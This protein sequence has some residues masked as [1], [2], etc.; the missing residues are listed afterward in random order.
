MSFLGKSFLATD[1]LSP[2]Q[3]LF[4]FEKARK[5]RDRKPYPAQNKTV[6]LMFFEPSTRTRASFEMAA[7]RLGLHV[8]TLDPS[9]SSVVKGETIEDTAANIEA[10]GPDCI[11]VRHSGAG[12]PQQLSRKVKIPV[13]NAG[14]GMRG[15]PTQALLDAFTILEERGQI[16]GEKVL[17]VGD[18]MHS[19]VARSNFE[20]LTKLGASIGV[21]GPATLRPPSLKEKGYQV[22]TNFEEGLEWATVCMLLRI[23]TERMESFQI[24]SM[25]EYNSRFGLTVDRLRFL[26]KNAIIMHPGPVNR[27]VEISSQ[28][29]E[30]S[31]CKILT[32]VKNGVFVRSALLSE[33]LGVEA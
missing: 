10:L 9:R 30:D 3:T 16:K 5:I 22:F 32:Q 24:P 19:R 17:L 11:V 2:E 6:A 23:Q 12:M 20:L 21:C 27:G 14:D 7:Y 26:N 28:A 18:I 1:S 31:R 25:D 33:I 8:L 4:L 15:H 13:V 29:M